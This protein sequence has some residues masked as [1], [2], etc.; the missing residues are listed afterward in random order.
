MCAFFCVCNQD[1]GRSKSPTFSVYLSYHIRDPTETYRCLKQC[2]YMHLSG[3]LFYCFTTV[4][5][6]RVISRILFS[7]LPVSTT[8]T[9][10][11]PELIVLKE[12][13]KRSSF[14]RKNVYKTSYQNIKTSIVSCS[15]Y[16]I[17]LHIESF[18][19]SDVWFLLP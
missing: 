15:T 18:V 1:S 6:F 19:C 2:L 7:Q 14:S 12:F 13:P 3:R 4:F 9:L 11:E 10:F 8:I 5:F 17:S 16:L